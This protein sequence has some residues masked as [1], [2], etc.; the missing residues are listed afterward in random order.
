MKLTGEYTFEATRDEVWAAL[1]DPTVLSRTLPGCE[2]LRQSGDNV[3]EGTMA[4]KVG[5]VQGVFQGKVELSDL[6]PPHGYTLS[7]SGKGAPGFVSGKGRLELEE[8]GGSTLLR[9]DV[10]A[11][12]GGRIAGVGQRLLDS[13]AKVITRQALEG[14]DAQIR[15]RKSAAASPEGA[16]A[17]PAPAPSQ[18]K[19]L[20]GV[21]GG[22]LGELIP[23]ERRAAVA[24]GGIGLALVILAVILRACG[25]GTA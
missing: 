5:P 17:A 13:S 8:A 1:L 9:Y 12:V 24:A 16:A 3:F 7:L 23:K 19:F 11:Q 15:Q 21:V 22:V 14:L 6:E 2:D 25:A 20:A 10:D 18:T 4:M